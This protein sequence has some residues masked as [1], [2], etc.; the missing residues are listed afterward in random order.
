MRPALRPLATALA[1][2]LAFAPAC[3]LE[4]PPVLLVNAR[5]GEHRLLVGELLL[6]HPDD[7]PHNRARRDHL[8]RLR[9]EVLAGGQ[10]VRVLSL[11]R[12]QTAAL[13]Y[14]VRLV[15]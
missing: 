8:G 5:L 10:V 1:L 6:A 14:F 15:T 13:I 4:F 9:H 3:L 12:L 7:L 11:V 2:A